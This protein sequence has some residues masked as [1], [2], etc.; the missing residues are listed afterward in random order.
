M[1]RVERLEDEF[2]EATSGVD[3]PE[4]K[5]YISQS[6]ESSYQTPSFLCFLSSDVADHELNLTEVAGLQFVHTGLCITREVVN[7][8]GSWN[9]VGVEP[10]QE[11]MK[12]LAAD[13]LVTLGFDN[14]LEYYDRATSIVNSF[15]TSKARMRNGS[16]SLEREANPYLEC[17]K[18]AVHVGTE[19]DQ[20]YEELYSFAENLAY[21]DCLRESRLFQDKGKME[22]YRSRA[23]D[24]ADGLL[25]SGYSGAFDRI[26]GDIDS[27]ASIESD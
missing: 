7:D 18:T 15:G 1:T 3:P 22:T 14:F 4:L 20:G 10:V 17:Y 25:D 23:R 27:R 8:G 5:S 11:D 16:N 24:S 13:V 6:L 26:Y 12:L 19:S 21:L 2:D 9:D